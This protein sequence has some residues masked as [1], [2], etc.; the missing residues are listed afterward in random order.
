MHINKTNKQVGQWWHMPLIPPFGRQRQVDFCEF[1]AS[2]VYRASLRT[3]RA[4]QRNPVSNKTNNTAEK[5][6]PLYPSDA[7]KMLEK[8]QLFVVLNCATKKLE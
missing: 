7:C 6:K 8:I 3:V 2:L 5:Q 4:T 1:D